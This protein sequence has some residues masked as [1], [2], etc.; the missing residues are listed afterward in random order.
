M[1]VL[2]LYKDYLMIEM[3]YSEDTVISYLNDVEQFEK[4]KV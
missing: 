4:Q 2:V 3:N 1:D